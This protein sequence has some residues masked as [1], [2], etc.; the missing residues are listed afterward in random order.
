MA[1]TV[2]QHVLSRLSEIGVKDVFGVP[3]DYAFP[4]NDAV[5]SD[6]SLRWIGSCNE[7]NAAYSADGYA[8]IRGVA[9][10][11]TTYAVGEL[12]AI[13]AIGGEF[14]RLCH[15]RDVLRFRAA[16]LPV[17]PTGLLSSQLIGSKQRNLV[18]G[19]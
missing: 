12:S 13:N 17:C 9:A 4:I 6:P 15:R 16:S 18:L 7:L 10:A 1:K 19:M 8:R 3:G 5:C 14:T 11:C 2:I